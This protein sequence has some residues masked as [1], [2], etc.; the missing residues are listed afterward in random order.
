MFI[1]VNKDEKSRLG[2]NK[3]RWFQAS[4][5]SNISYL[6]VVD[7]HGFFC[8]KKLKISSWVKRDCNYIY[9]LINVPSHLV[10]FCRVDLFV[11]WTQQNI[12]WLFVQK[13]LFIYVK[14][15]LVDITVGIKHKPSIFTQ[16]YYKVITERN[17]RTHACIHA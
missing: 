17:L 2:R 14:L 10:M 12:W 15:F 8:A 11:V 3:S 13:M 1:F 6:F 7:I 4:S 5:C 16:K 9:S